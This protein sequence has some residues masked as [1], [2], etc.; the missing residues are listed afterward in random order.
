MTV[1]KAIALCAAAI[2]LSMLLGCAGTQSGLGWSKGNVPPGVSPEIAAQADV[3]AEYLFV[4]RVREKEAQEL[5]AKGIRHYAVTDSLWKLLAEMRKKNAP[6]AKP[7]ADSVKSSNAAL[8]THNPTGPRSRIGAVDILDSRTTIQAKYNLLEAR[9]NL[10]TALA[11]DPYKPVVKH[12][13]ALTYKLFAERFPGDVSLERAAEQWRELAELEPGEYLHY[14]NLGGLHYARQQWQEAFL[15]FQKTEQILADYAEVSDARVDNPALPRAAGTDSARWFDSIYLQAQSLI[16]VA[17]GKQYHG[18][19]PEA[20]ATLRLLEHAKSLAPEPQ[21]QAL[22]EGDIKWVQWDSLNIWGSAQRDTA[23]ALVNRGQFEE[24]DKI[25]HDLFN[26]ILQTKRAKDDARWDYATITYIKLKRR[27]LAIDRLTEVIHG[28]A[29]DTSGAPRDTTYNR[30]FE[31]YGAMCYNLGLDTMKVDRKVAFQYFEHAA[32]VKWK[33]R[34]RCYLLMADL[35]KT[36]TE[37]SLKHAETA[38]ALSDQFTT[39]E[40]KGVYRLLIDGYRRKNLMDK[41]RLY[42]EKFREL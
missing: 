19:T 2:I 24:A 30:M 12:Y 10:E 15:N 25:F 36:N 6:P 40:M 4:P 16:R 22:I 34:G 42:M 18:R 29:Q 21:W 39:E 7:A 32:A 27:A 33:E 23:S 37:L 26:N 41:A 9:K 3:I 11:R 1:S 14:Y 28:I 35:S 20:D 17:I 13:L 5:S 38:L 8:T 31:D